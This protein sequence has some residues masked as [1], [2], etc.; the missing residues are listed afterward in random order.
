MVKSSYIKAFLIENRV[1]DQSIV[2]IFPKD[3]SKLYY[4]L[5][6]MN[7]DAINE[8]IHTINPTANNSANYV[9]QIPYIEPEQNVVDL[10]SS[11]V[12][13]IINNFKSGH[14]SENTVIHSDVNFLKIG[15]FSF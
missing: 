8:L 13:T 6:I 5:A 4:I 11:K 1:F 3:K 7:S 15:N 14:D 12:E 9:K 2:G 10:I